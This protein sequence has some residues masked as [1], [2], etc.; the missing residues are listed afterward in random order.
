MSFF[1]RF[2]RLLTPT[3]IPTSL[4]LSSEPIDHPFRSVCYLYCYD[5]SALPLPLRHFSLAVFARFFF[6]TL[7]IYDALPYVPYILFPVRFLLAFLT[8]TRYLTR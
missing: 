1:C 6:P 3:R 7:C 4:L 2:L 5:R 8:D